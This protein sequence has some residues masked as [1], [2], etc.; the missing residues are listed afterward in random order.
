MH[1]PTSAARVSPDDWRAFLK[2]N[3]DLEAIDAFII[4]VN[5]NTTGKRLPVSDGGKLFADGVQF[6]ACAPIADARGLGQGP[7][8]IG[9][10]D[11]DP[12]GTA[13][14]V[15]GTL[16]RV[17]WV[18]APTA[19]VV[20]QMT[21][22][23]SGRNMWFDARAILGDLV[24]RCHAA[25]VH[26]VVACELEF[27]LIDVRRG[28]EGQIHLGALPGRSAPRRAANLSVEAVEEA[29][30]FFAGIDAAA[31]VQQLPVCGTVAEYGVGQ[32][33]VNLRH[34]ADPLQAADHAVLLKRLVKGVAR[35][36]GLDATFMA[37]PF[38]A[39]PGN[40]LH[41]HVSLVDEAGSNRFG[42]AQGEILLQHAIAGAQALMYDSL[43]L[44]APNFN[45][46]RR[47]LG[48]FVPTTRDWD[49]NNRSV[50][51]RVPAAQGQARRLE[52]RV[53]GA[54]ASPHLTMAAILAG[55]LHGVQNGLDPG[56]P[57]GGKARS[58]RD[59]DFPCDL[60]A[61]LARLEQSTLLGQYLPP[62]FLRL[63][64][65]LK[66]GEYADLIADVFNREY[67]FYA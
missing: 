19:Q 46:Q 59:A 28:P 15:A 37:K 14:P 32:Y 34:V 52:H 35:S 18:K 51:F 65:A 9:K 42:A 47:Y 67:D 29:A 31:R 4:D 49:H 55:V 21:D 38:A 30:A 44:F 63:Y 39:Q 40:G 41:V 2:A 64:A 23:H 62:D 16:Q 11:G 12:D 7:M 33:E 66:R 10:A 20:C 50:A 5:G 25:G 36:F 48:M 26:P 8:G 27:Y 43:A 6:S 60:L 1:A 45:S 53:A 54:D 22:V 17:P 56:A 61:A 58:G 3:P 24:A 13:W 57:L